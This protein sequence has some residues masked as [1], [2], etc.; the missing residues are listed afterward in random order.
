V[1]RKKRQTS[2]H[3]WIRISA[4]VIFC[5]ASCFVIYLFIITQP[6][7][8]FARYWASKLGYPLRKEE[9]RRD[10][11]ATIGKHR[12]SILIDDIGYDPGPLKEL[13]KIDAPISFSILPYCTHS[14]DAA[15]EIY[16]AGKEIFLHLPMEPH[17][18]PQND[19]GAGSLFL[20]M[21]DD[22]IR[23][24]IVRDLKA[25]P[26]ASGVNNHMGSR[27][28][29]DKEKLRIVFEVLKERN[30]PFVD[31]LTTTESKAGELAAESGVKFA[32]RQVFIDN[33]QNH[34][35]IIR[36]FNFLIR[37]KS[38][39]KN[40]V[41]IGHP[42][43]ATLTA[44][45]EAIPILRSEGIEIVPVSNMVKTGEDGLIG[46]NHRVRTDHAKAP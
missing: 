41:L 15:R 29:E 18:Y 30:L 9:A 4:G 43:P 32:S 7:G 10:A 40:L 3:D 14:T 33:E 45:K 38:Q 12:I 25:V 37:T 46:E 5:F 26:H 2:R 23:R 13:L 22:A 34:D 35:A 8:P 28:M 27:F 19:P 24:T 39:W 20:K 21:D 1:R 6:P 16:R 17:D 44:L 11:A 42:H 36:K 31:S